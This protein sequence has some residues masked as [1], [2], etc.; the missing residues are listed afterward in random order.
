MRRREVYVGGS[1][2]GRE[3]DGMGKDNKYQR[4]LERN[5]LIYKTAHTHTNIYMEDIYIYLPAQGLV[6]L[7]EAMG[8]HI[9]TSV[10]G[11]SY[12]QV[13]VIPKTSKII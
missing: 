1:C 13:T 3:E 9:K 11:M 4:H 2:E 8:C 6:I 7:P 12:F 10:T 5:L